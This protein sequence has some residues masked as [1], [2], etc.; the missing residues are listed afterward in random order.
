MSQMTRTL[1]FVIAASLAVIGAV[2]AHVM[3]RPPTIEEG[4][5]DIGEEFYPAFTEPES[6]TALRVAAWN[7]ASNRVEQFEVRNNGGKWVIPSHNNYPADGEQQLARAAASAVGIVR[8]S[9]ASQ[10][11]QSHAR[12][13]VI[14]PLDAAA[15]QGPGETGT[16]ITL[17]DKD[18]P[19]ADY[20]IGQRVG[21]V[22][23]EGDTTPP[24][25]DAG[26]RQEKA[27]RYYVRT[28]DDVRVFVADVKIDVSTRFRDWIEKNLLE[29]TSTDLR[30]IVVDQYSVD[31][32][33]WAI[34]QQMRAARQIGADEILDGVL[35]QGDIS[36]LSRETASSPWQLAGMDPA[37]EKV[38]ASVV[39]AMSRALAGLQI[40]GIRKKP[41]ALV[42]FFRDG[43]I[44]QFEA[45]E[46]QLDLAQHG[47][48]FDGRHLLSNEGE[49]AAG[50]KDGVLY[51]LR[52]GEVFT[53]SELE[54]EVG[55]DAAG[56]TASDTTSTGES[57]T[58]SATATTET[59]A[60]DDE[61]AADDT[62][63]AAGTDSDEDAAGESDAD[64]AQRSRYVIVMADFDATL[65]G[66]KPTPPTKPEPPTPANA[67]A[68]DA[69]APAGDDAPENEDAPTTDAAPETPEAP[70]TESAPD[71]AADATIE[72]TDAS[73][74]NCDDPAP[75]ATE[76]D[77]TTPAADA[78][79][80]EA[81]AGDATTPETGTE[82]PAADP[83]TLAVDPAAPETSPAATTDPIQRPRTPQDDYRDALAVYEREQQ[84]YEV[85][86]EEYE[87]QLKEG[88]ARV[89][90]LN[91]RFA[92][93]YYVIPADIF[94]DLRVSRDQLVEPVT[95][96]ADPAGFDPSTIDP[97][98]IPGLESLIPGLSIDPTAPANEP[99][100]T[101]PATDP[102][103]SPDASS[104]APATENEPASDAPTTDAAPPADK[105]A[106]ESTS[107]SE[108]ADP[109]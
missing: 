101:E 44:D 36:E 43:F 62:E 73:A 17:F 91:A 63:P 16:R 100:A 52:F 40:V 32:S 83:A 35:E 59:P 90:E 7:P 31:E 81:A 14:D 89:Q 74:G 18:Q 107:D 102:A 3:T 104:E 21:D 97:A 53:G 94:E 28:P 58:E 61:S 47:F 92:E 66:P 105:T 26:G 72:E 41:E 88:E 24:P 27:G 86:L 57:T 70:A 96:G 20:I 22:A 79:T 106:P 38:K 48:Y 46:V 98:S 1:M 55:T 71:A 65:L 50:S 64:S 13:G 108:A 109:S 29:L 25:A 15:T 103:S 51:T 33:R 23:V 42:K 10:Q 84:L 12:F 19:L 69:T 45:G 49:I 85:R 78:A 6:A 37:T 8:G 34:W 30:R 99:E 76:S 82:T 4:Y 9:I 80:E 56:A 67:P 68:T 11:K 5:S 93:W 54:V 75:A 87:R 60:A 2:L 77:T 95:A 39:S